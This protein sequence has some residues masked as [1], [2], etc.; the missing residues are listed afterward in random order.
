[1]FAR[2]CSRSLLYST[3]FFSAVVVAIGIGLWS[4]EF[5]C[6][7]GKAYSTYGN[8]SC[9]PSV[10]PDEGGEKAECLEYVARFLQLPKQA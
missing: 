10:I 4:P 5:Q 9:S 1:M 2:K 8:S 7:E 3:V 6:P